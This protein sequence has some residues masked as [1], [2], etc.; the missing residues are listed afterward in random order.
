MRTSQ[1]RKTVT[2]TSPKRAEVPCAQRSCLHGRLSGSF[3]LP[4][5]RQQRDSRDARVYDFYLREFFFLFCYGRR[6][7]QALIQI[8]PPLVHFN[9]RGQIR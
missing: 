8:N 4:V 9:G 7:F 1:P 5:M 6:V 2:K 3:L